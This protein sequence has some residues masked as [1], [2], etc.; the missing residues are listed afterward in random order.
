MGIFDGILGAVAPAIGGLFGG[1]VGG[2]IGSF[3]GGLFGDEDEPM[4]FDTSGFGSAL[5]SGISGLIGQQGARQQNVENLALMRETQNFNSAEALKNRDFQMERSERAMGFTH[6]EAQRQMAFQREMSSTAYQRAVAD[7]QAAGLNPMLA[8]HQ[9]GATTPAGASGSG[10]ASGGSAA[11]GVSAHMENVKSQMLQSAMQ[12]ATV[13]ASIEKI[14]AETDETKS[15]E[16]VN[17]ATVPKVRQETLTSTSTARNLEARTQ[18]IYTRLAEILPEEK[19]LLAAQTIERLNSAT[20]HGAH[21]AQSVAQRDLLFAQYRTELEKKGL[22]HAEVGRVLAE[23]KLLELEQPGAENRSKF[24]ENW[25]RYN[26]SV[27]PF[28]PDFLKGATS[29]AILHRMTR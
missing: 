17:L 3:V 8:Y 21:A 16:L 1:P 12:A 27:S 14:R 25:P 11:S 15:R 20:L 10:S 9:G 13:Q 18:D 5:S 28:L 24:Q 22:T 26:Q 7:M 23:T 4:E 2:A 29:G 19:A 6:G